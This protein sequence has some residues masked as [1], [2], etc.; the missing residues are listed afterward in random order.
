MCVCV[1][2]NTKVIFFSKLGSRLIHQED[3]Y[4]RCV[5]GLPVCGQVHTYPGLP[6]SKCS[7]SH[8]WNRSTEQF[9]RGNVQ[10]AAPP[11]LTEWKNYPAQGRPGDFLSCKCEK[12][13]YRVRVNVSLAE[14]VAMY[15]SS[16]FQEVRKGSLQQQKEWRWASAKCRGK[17]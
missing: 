14:P 12:E 16:V 5:I 10:C 8:L 3:V 11:L 7:L 4:P 17:W 2:F 6:Y 13:M 9:L 15:F 1:C